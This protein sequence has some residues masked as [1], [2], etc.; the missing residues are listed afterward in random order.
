MESSESRSPL[1]EPPP[2]FWTPRRVRSALL[3]TVLLG[4]ALRL[5]NLGGHVFIEDEIYTLNVAR[6]SLDSVL[7]SGGDPS[8]PPLHYLLLNLL[9]GAASG[10]AALRLPAAAFGILSIPLLH[11]AGRRLLGEGP[12]LAAA[13]L[14]AL[15]GFHVFW[16][17]NGRMYSTYLFF[18]L[19]SM[20][21]YLRLGSG[22]RAW[23]QYVAATV[24]AF[25]THYFTGFL[26]LA[27]VAAFPF[28]PGRQGPRPWLTLLGALA[29]VAA[30]AAPA[31]AL[32]VPAQLAE[33]TREA[34][35]LEL[36]PLPLHVYFPWMFD[37]F[38]VANWAASAPFQALA[39]IGAIRLWMRDR[40]TCL[41]LLLWLL[42]PLAAGWPVHYFLENIGS[43]MFIASMPALY[44][45]IAAGLVAAGRAA[46]GSREG[47]AWSGRWAAGA[48]LGLLAA[49]S[50]GSVADHYANP[51]EPFP[52]RDIASTLGSNV[53]PGDSLLAVPSFHEIHLNHY[54]PPTHSH[55]LNHANTLPS[56]RDAV[57]NRSRPGTLWYLQFGDVATLP[58]FR[59]I[60]SYIDANFLPVRIEPPLWGLFK[61]AP[62]PPE[63]A[64][65]HSPT[66]GF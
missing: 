18:A 11:R 58:G 52:W 22:K 28:S 43:R 9:P 38:T 24:A 26:V 33:R 44:L 7:R 12:A 16:S 49:L 46:A 37:Q 64:T 35:G 60:A 45:L 30:A 13:L 4:A 47:G 48:V 21:G 29:L 31:V 17:Q 8:H 32:L 61:R 53:G 14:L 63:N 34:V 10:E 36:E 50:A 23:V 65:P 1:P 27:Q 40:K 57:E 5:H 39:A 41:L 62:L 20:D 3:L 19:L 6:G 51:E 25:Y 2:D 59:G 42:L 55:W 66:S 56:I 15:S 54:W